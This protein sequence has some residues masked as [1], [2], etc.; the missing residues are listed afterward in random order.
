M[1][2]F[3]D[4]SVPLLVLSGPVHALMAPMA[5][6]DDSYANQHLDLYCGQNY[7]AACSA[8]VQ[9]LCFSRRVLRLCNSW[10]CSLFI[11]H[12][13]PPCQGKFC[14]C[15]ARPEL[16]RSG[17]QPR[18]KRWPGDPGK[19]SVCHRE[20]CMRSIDVLLLMNTVHHS[21][22]ILFVFWC[23]VKCP[24]DTLVLFQCPH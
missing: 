13:F 19:S 11:G 23:F 18:S 9:Q 4:L 8:L 22:L 7:F 16:L 5:M 6:H 2:G 21:V 17:A 3:V 10:S 20:I 12:S 24:H 1:T 15:L 14:L